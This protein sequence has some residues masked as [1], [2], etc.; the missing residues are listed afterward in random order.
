[1]DDYTKLLSAALDL[2]IEWMV[3]SGF[4]FDNI[5]EEYEVYKDEIS[6]MSY[7]QGLHYIIVTEA[8][9]RRK[10]GKLLP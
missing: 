9:R 5:P 6:M 4:G 8:E 3:E 1:M 10:I 2:A 7:T